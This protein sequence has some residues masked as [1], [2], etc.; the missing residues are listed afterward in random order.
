MTRNKRNER[1]GSESVNKQGCLM[2]VVEYVNANNILV[3]FIGEYPCVIKSN[4]GDFV[5]N[6]ILNP[7][8]PTIFNKGI[9][10]NKYPTESN[11][12]KCKEYATWLGVM[13]RA[14]S[15]KKDIHNLQ[16]YKNVACCEEWLLYDNF[17]EWVH[18]QENFKQWIKD[19]MSAIDKDILVKNN[20][21]YSPDTCCLV[22]LSV[23]NLFI[24]EK[25]RRGRYPIGV[26]KYKN[27]EDFVAQ[28]QDKRNNPERQVFLGY[29]KTP[30]EAFY[31]YKKY[32]EKLIK[33]IAQ[34]EYD[35]GNITKKCY[36][37]MIKYEI[38]ITD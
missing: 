23:N 3:E 38:E 26:S 13:E 29:F 9:V 25:S 11:G 10:G 8:Y 27:R 31:A 2:R 32:K 21:I 16:S 36:E 14:L 15:C 30:E 6:R 4:W 35:K 17:Y 20:K 37:A 22:P 18:S 7:Y 24:R 34:E 28:C 19:P 33:Q 5:R 12:K 1:I